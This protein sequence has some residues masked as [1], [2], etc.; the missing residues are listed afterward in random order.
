MRNCILSRCYKRLLHRPL[1][2][3][4]LQLRRYNVL[5]KSS[6]VDLLRAWPRLLSSLLVPIIEIRLQD[7]INTT[8]AREH[9]QRLVARQFLLASLRPC[10]R[11][12]KERVVEGIKKR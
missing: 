8:I 10:S 4:A 5:T 1:C 2:F 6:L 7:F 3:V 11:T 9:H 12:A